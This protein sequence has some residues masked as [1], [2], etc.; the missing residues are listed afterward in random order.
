MESDFEDWPDD[1]E[2]TPKQTRYRRG[3]YG[4]VNSSENDYEDETE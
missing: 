2:D 4:G 1:E 3:T